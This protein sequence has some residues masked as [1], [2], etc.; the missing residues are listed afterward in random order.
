MAGATLPGRRQR[1]TLPA[2]TFERSPSRLREVPRGMT[3]T[4]LS[5]QFAEMPP[6][7]S[8]C[9]AKGVIGVD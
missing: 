6:D 5:C 7:L 8:Q 2:L 4:C 9:G 3:D 1:R